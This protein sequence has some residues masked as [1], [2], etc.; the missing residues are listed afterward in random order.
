MNITKKILLTTISLTSLFCATASFALAPSSISNIYVFGD[1]LSDC[2]VTDNLP[3]PNHPNNT[4]TTPGGLVWSQ[5]LGKD[6]G[7]PVTPNNDYKLYMKTYP[8]RISDPGS[9]V[10]QTEEGNCYAAGGA[11][12]SG[13]GLG[14]GSLYAPPSVNDQVQNFLLQHNNAADPNALYIIW[15]GA[16]NILKLLA[17]NNTNPADYAKASSTAASD[18]VG[19]V[20]ALKSHGAKHIVVVSLPN[21]ADT[22]LIKM[23]AKSNPMIEQMTL[24]VS[25]NFN[26]GLNNALAGTGVV[27]FD[28]F[29]LIHKIVTSIPYTDPYSGTQITNAT[30]AACDISAGS[31]VTARTCIPESGT[32]DYMFADGIHP[33]A[34]AHNILAK[35]LEHLIE[36]SNF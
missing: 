29:A 2:G 35:E 11:T 6:F 7:R 30:G 5:Q 33:T 36:S 28:T 31:N 27:Y 9:V 15:A 19:E 25:M 14:M 12:T 34:V 22:A 23:Q 16:N 32:T 21:L 3:V 20:N 18:I 4:F 13:T 24:A 10:S 8:G 17:N 1:S 26:T